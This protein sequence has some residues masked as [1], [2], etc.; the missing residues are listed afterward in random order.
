MAEGKTTGPQD[1]AADDGARR[2]DEKSS[3]NNEQLRANG[4]EAV[5]KLLHLMSRDVAEVR[6][7]CHAAGTFLVTQLVEACSDA[8]L[9]EH[10]DRLGAAAAD[11]RGRS[12]EAPGPI[13]M[14]MKC[15]RFVVLRAP[16]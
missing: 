4:S 13:L 10:C 7:A 2:G 6:A 1:G 8:E 5:E 11:L 15:A 3:E 14:D 12:G 9:A 16:R